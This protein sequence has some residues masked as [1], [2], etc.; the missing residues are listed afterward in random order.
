MLYLPLYDGLLSLEIGIA[1]TSEISSQNKSGNTNYLDW[2]YIIFAHVFW[3]KPLYF[4]SEKNELLKQIFLKQK[5]NGDRNIYYVKADKLIGKD[6]EY[7]V[8]GVHLT[9]L[10]FLRMAENL[11]PIIK[12]RID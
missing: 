10:G 12:K 1:P 7:A 8:D 6:A 3:S 9:D 4:N 5:K 11:Y 2:E